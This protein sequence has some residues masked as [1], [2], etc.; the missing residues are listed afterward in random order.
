MP[1]D[2][3][4]A[5][6]P[7]LLEGDIGDAALLNIG[8]T[9]LRG[10]GGDSAGGLNSGGGSGGE[11]IDSDRTREGRRATIVSGSLHWIRFTERYHVPS[12]VTASSDSVIVEGLYA[13]ARG[14]RMIW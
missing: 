4:E 14:M 2:V 3:S 1:G 5:K 9:L 11:S 13:L 10:T 12:G 7:I 6:S 8:E